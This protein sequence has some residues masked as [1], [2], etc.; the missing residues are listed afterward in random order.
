MMDTTTSE[1]E[2]LSALILAAMPDP[3]ELRSIFGIWKSIG[4]P[5]N[6]TFGIAIYRLV[7]QRKIK[8][9]SVAGQSLFRRL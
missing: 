3:P 4:Q 6:K 7:A 9:C 2:A 5:P 1:V 8:R